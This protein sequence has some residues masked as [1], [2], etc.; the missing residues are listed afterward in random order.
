MSGCGKVGGTGD[1]VDGWAETGDLASAGR[2]A[3]VSAAQ[4]SLGSKF[5]RSG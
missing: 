1:R 5:D 3:C 2:A 4:A